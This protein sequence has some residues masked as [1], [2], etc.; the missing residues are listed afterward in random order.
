MHGYSDRINHA[1]AFT[2]KHYRPSAP[3][4][5][6]MGQAAHPA[7][8]ALILA[9]YGCDQATIVAGIVHHILEESR[10]DQRAVFE[11]KIGEKFGPVVLA[12]ARDAAELRY[13]ERGER[14]W[15]ARK[16]DMLAHLGVAEPRALDVIA[17]DE[18]HCC[19]ATL[20]ALRRLGTEYLGSVSQADSEQV[21]WWYR[22][23]L[24]VLTAR[25][26]WPQRPMLDEIRALSADLARSLQ[27]RE[28]EL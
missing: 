3:P 22:S 13:A 21:I 20:A 6:G 8:V 17:A 18:I 16:L 12:I 19:G 4:W 10:S 25:A 28:E 27:E 15:R 1:L 14:P 7:N 24:E 11:G 23:M 2:A 5:G 9:R 26:D